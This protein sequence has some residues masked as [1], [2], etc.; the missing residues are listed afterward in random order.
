[1]AIVKFVAARCPMSYI[2]KYVMR[3]EATERK[4]ID[5]V[6]CSP[7]SAMEEFI[8]TKQQFHKEDGRQYYHIV[9]SFS[10]D[11]N[12]TPEMAHQIGMEFVAC[13]PGYQVLVATHTNTRSVHNHLIMNS[14]NYEN[15]K[16]FHISRDQMLEYKRLSNG[17]C[18]KY[19]LS[20][21]EPKTKKKSRWKDD[22]IDLLYD[23]LRN[24]ATKEDFIEFM[25]FHGYKVKWEDKYK[26]IT[27]TA[28]DGIKVR[29][30]KLFDECL[31]KDNLEL[32]FMTGGC[33]GE[34]AGVYL[35]YET[36]VH[37][38][39]ATMTLSTGLIEMMGDILSAIK[40]EP[41]YTPQHLNEMSQTE[42]AAI[43][44]ILGRKITNEAYLTYCTRED[45][46]QQAGI[47]Q[48]W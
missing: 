43:E 39:T 35:D 29:D 18:H 44:K 1:M 11:D 12:V 13:F 19:G 9:Q 8:Y 22:L 40:D 46:E 21:T 32:Y 33:Y 31:L 26:Y 41:G 3:K 23:A 7:V 27:F 45:Y 28:P 6:N 2:F 10:P 24:T 34:L 25:E 36:P 47:R 20:I 5:G 4:L 48:S 17:I 38:E 30:S 37:P 16:K 14:V 42:K 15:G